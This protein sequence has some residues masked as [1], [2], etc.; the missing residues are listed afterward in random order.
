MNQ[1]IKCGP[2]A[3]IWDDGYDLPPL[4]RGIHDY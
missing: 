1:G 3:D 4:S 2:L